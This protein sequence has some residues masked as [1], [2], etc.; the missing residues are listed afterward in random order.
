MRLD[1][2]SGSIART[3]FEEPVEEPAMRLPLALMTAVVALAALMFYA[4]GAS[5][6]GSKADGE[7]KAAVCAACHGPKG[8]SVNPLWPSLAGQQEAYLAKQIK[9]FRDG[10]RVEPT[11]QPF[12]ANLSDQD[13]DD[14]AAYY[15]SLSPCP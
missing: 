13:A 12:V 8:I 7:T 6:A 10:V 11:M 5:G 2:T 4:T 3:C 15:A 1:R 9:E 14:L